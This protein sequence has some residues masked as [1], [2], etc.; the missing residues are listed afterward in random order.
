M[1]GKNSSPSLNQDE[2]S[3]FLHFLVYFQFHSLLD[4][5]IDFIVLK[6]YTTCIV[7]AVHDYLRLTPNQLNKRTVHTLLAVCYHQVL[8]Y[9]Q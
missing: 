4:A 9:L 5:D 1:Q 6:S 7:T 3:F 2:K 8:L